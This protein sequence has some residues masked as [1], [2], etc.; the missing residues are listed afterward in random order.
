MTNYQD[1]LQDLQEIRQMMARSTRFL[2]LSGLAGISTGLIALAGAVAAWW[3]LG[4]QWDYLNAPA[5]YEGMDLL[6]FFLI[7]AALVV[8]LAAGS[9]LYFSWRKAQKQ[10]LPFWNAAARNLLSSLLIP[11]VAGGL[12]CVIQVASGSYRWV[13]ATM[14]LF[15]GMALLNA[16][17]YTLK[18]I[19]YLGITQIVLGIFCAW[20]SYYG[21][22]FWAVGFG[23][24]H[25]L[26]GIVMYL[27]YER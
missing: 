26:Y 24:M 15:Y 6:T 27:T 17:K 7:D 14:L 5:R 8:V 1:K 10:V 11:L 21:L 20:F 25:I 23:L 4:A 13:A 19:G 18:E 16:S 3:R 2:S 22:Y 12:F 9:A